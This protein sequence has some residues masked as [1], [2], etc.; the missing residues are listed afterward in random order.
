MISVILPLYNGERFIQGAIGSILD[1]SVG[2]FQIIAVDDGGTEPTLARVEAMEGQIKAGGHRLEVVVLKGNR[3]IAAARNAG[4]A[5]AEG[6]YLAWLDQDDLWPS[7]RTATLLQALEESGATVAR[8]RMRFVDLAPDSLR[9]WVRDT[10]FSGNHTGYVLGA[11]LCRREVLERVGPLQTAFAGGFDD[12][13]WF[14]R[15]RH[16]QVP[17]VDVDAVT[18]VRQIH[19]SNQSGRASQSELLAVVRAHLQRSRNPS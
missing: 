8:G 16:D 9:P 14:M 1:Q 18:V 7:D 5:I 12:V 15:L 6:T 4:A 3:G 19:T 11:L 17:L 13:D 10:W 2:E